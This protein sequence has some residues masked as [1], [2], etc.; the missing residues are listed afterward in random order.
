MV[1]DVSVK[2]SIVL[3]S[4]WPP[5]GELSPPLSPTLYEVLTECPLKATFSVSSDYPERV[6]P[7]AR[8]GIA[9]HRA[10]D[11]IHRELPKAEGSS[12]K[13]FR[14]FGARVFH[15]IV[16]EEVRRSRLKMREEWLV[17]PLEL[18]NKM[19]IT[20][21]LTAGHLLEEF[22]SRK[23]LE[24]RFLSS[25]SEQV[26]NLLLSQDGLI[27]GKPDL[28]TRDGGERVIIDYKTGEIGDNK[29]RER[30]TRQ[31]FV[32]AY[33]WHDNFGEW[34]DVVRLENP[35]TRETYQV[36]LE[37]CEAIRIA[38]EMKMVA[39]SLPDLSS[40]TDKASIGT[41]CYECQFRP[42]CEPFWQANLEQIAVCPFEDSNLESISFEGYI[43][44]VSNTAPASQ[45]SCHAII[46]VG[47]N[48]VHVESN[49]EKHRHVSSLQLGMPVRVLDGIGRSRERPL[50]VKL[51]SWSEIYQL[52]R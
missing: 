38:E 34:P 5:K 35:I 16:E 49:S 45:V 1:G 25:P 26:E 20:V 37:P 13:E 31:L 12:I 3:S 9:F 19:E 29:E 21:G 36:Q 46:Q 33:L 39:L 22:H 4:T 17:W 32:Y 7:R 30:F 2:W 14:W 18:R 48:A 51:G 47:S 15:E 24:G 44:K 42:W 10:L 50:V 6:S 40:S 23:G 43:K 41:H 8:L 27:H 52:V 28:V 11:A